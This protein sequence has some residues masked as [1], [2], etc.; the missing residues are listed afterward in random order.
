MPLDPGIPFQALGGGNMVQPVSPFQ[1][2]GDIMKL[3][4]GQQRINENDDLLK[5]KQ[6][7][8]DDDNAIRTVVQQHAS[9]LQP[10]Q[11]LDFN[12]IITDLHA[13]GRPGAAFKVQD[14]VFKS[15]KDK[16]D[17]LKTT[18]D[19]NKTRLDIAIK[20]A[21]G[22][23]D[24]SSFDR[25]MPQLTSLVGPDL[26]KQFGT[27]YDADTI[28]QLV[29]SGYSISDQLKEQSD[30]F[31][32]SQK[33]ITQQAEALKNGRDWEAKKPTIV[34]DW[35]NLGSQYLSLSKTPDDWAHGLQMLQ[36]GVSGLPKE[37]QDAVLSKFAT[38]FSPQAVDD[39]RKLGMTQSQRSNETL[40]RAKLADAE[41]ARKASDDA[42]LSPEAVDMLSQNFARTGNLP[43]MGLGTTAAAN[44]VKVF[45]NAATVFKGLNLAE[46][47]AAVKSYQQSINRLQPQY[48]SLQSF[49]NTALKNTGIFLDSAK[50]IVDTGS[51]VLNTPI[52]SASDQL[53]GSDKMAAFKTAR[54]TVI[55]E[56]ARILQGGTLG[57]QPLTD[58]MRKDIDSIL[59][60]NATLG[61]L[62][63]SA[64]V[65]W[66]D[67]ENRRTSMKDQIDSLHKLI[68]AAPTSFITPGN[69]PTPGTTRMRAPNGQV[70]DVPNDQVARAK[71]AGAV[72]IGGGS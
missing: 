6:Q 1:T 30:I 39:A 7:A 46:Q 52:R 24:Q 28:K 35:T 42:P 3:R 69:A 5:Q 23:T 51:P 66:Q 58:S 29:K 62:Y 61:Q 33:L 47:S 13:M 8:Q 9:N 15:N 44:R 26:A 55:P 57:G 27:Q 64:N 4:E 72:V 50:K 12:G 25:A 32:R 37:V 53:L 54:E 63:A 16:A 60:G 20:M 45:N 70:S 19:A 65:L 41:A 10:G 17:E 59:A 48:D 38:S 56:F 36:G 21:E 14:Q 34:N 22:I 71:A 18:A 40:D 49:E 2:L 43:P 11:P 31:D 67:A 68:G